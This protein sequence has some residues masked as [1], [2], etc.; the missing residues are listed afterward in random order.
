MLHT[1]SHRPLVFSVNIC[2][3]RLF[4]EEYLKVIN[5]L[6]ICG[7]DDEEIKDLIESG[8]KSGYDGVE[9]TE[10]LRFFVKENNEEL[11]GKWIHV[12]DRNIMK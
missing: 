2:P 8:K 7:W 1:H 10:Y 3:T 6:K 11:E 9:F 4:T 12:R 5:Q